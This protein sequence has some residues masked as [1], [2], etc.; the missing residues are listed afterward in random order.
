MSARQ[1][2]INVNVLPSGSHAANWR[3][4]DG[5]RFGFIEIEHYQ[6]VARIAERGLLDAVFLADALAIAPD[7]S[8]GP[9]WALDPVVIVTGMAAVTES[10]GF[11]ASASTTYS[12]PYNIARAFLSLDHVSRGRVGWNV[13]TTYD[14]RAA[15]NFG[16]RN[17][18]VHEDRYGRAQ[19]FVEVVLG[20][21]DS[22]EDEA[23]VGDRKSGLFADPKRIHRLDHAGQI[24]SVQGPMQ[25]PRSPQGRPLLVQAGGSDQGRELAARYAEA[26]FSV[27][28]V[29]EEARTFYADVKARARRLGRDPDTIAILPG[30]SLIIGGTEAEALARKKDLDEIAE[31]GRALERFA[32]RLGVDPKDLDYD[33]PVPERLLE[34][35]QNASGSRGF[36]DA[37]VA[38]LKDRSLTVREIMEQ[39][40]GRHRVVV[41][42]PEQIADTIEQWFTTG[43]ADGFNIMCDVFPTGLVAFVD[44]VVPVLQKRGLF[45]RAYSGKT[46]RDHYGLP[47]PAN[48]FAGRTAPARRSA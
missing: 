31:D 3:A 46:L 36:I 43:A 7:P 12:H 6:E 18:P 11:I 33:L 32:G 29:I 20:L 23:L 17:L 44:H 4:P 39:G 13:V 25:L 38:L 15:P 28:H 27:Q 41:G 1:L 42:A 10:I 37:T 22:W 16:Q 14:Q 35:I 40:G 2:H 26:V 24:F 5:H 9:T 19:E 45:R 47:R 34:R 30:L 8:F 21:W 48:I